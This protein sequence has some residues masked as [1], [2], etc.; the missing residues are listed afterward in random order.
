MKWDPAQY[1]RFADERG[2]PFQD[3]M[4]RVGGRARR[5]RVVDLG[6]GPGNLT[7]G[8]ADRW[9]GADIE[10]VDSSA[11]M[12]ERARAGPARDRLRFSVGRPARV[13]AAAAGRR[14]HLQRDAAV[15]PRPPGPPRATGRVRRARR[16]VRL[17]G[18]R[19]LRRADHTEL[20]A[21]RTSPRWR[22]LWPASTLPQPA[23]EEP[24]VRRA[25][26]GARLRGR[27][28]GDDVPARAR[29]PGRGAAS[30]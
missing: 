17:P 19:Q 24:D 20:A 7:V 27:R 21:L 30:G 22:P 3:L 29:R 15:G 10:G 6:C 8:L 14:A 11:E 5:R 4:A 16:L 23:V 12:I 26:G 9:P 28:L 13:G 18:A 1:L 25:A 2:R